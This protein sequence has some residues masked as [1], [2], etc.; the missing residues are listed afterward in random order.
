MAGYNKD[1]VKVALNRESN[2]RANVKDKVDISSQAWKARM[3]PSAEERS[4]LE[5]DSDSII[6]RRYTLETDVNEVTKVENDG[7]N[8]LKVTAAGHGYSNSDNVVLGGFSN[9]SINVQGTVSSETTDTFVVAEIAWSSSY[10]GDTGYVAKVSDSITGDELRI[11][12]DQIVEDRIPFG[13]KDN[14]YPFKN[15]DDCTDYYDNFVIV[16]HVKQVTSAT[17]SYLR[18]EER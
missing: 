1:T 10:S 9:E 2:P 18:I 13:M 4:Y 17:S 15:G 11:Q 5:F 16:L 12:A 7:S 14:Y 8:Q 6:N 3:L